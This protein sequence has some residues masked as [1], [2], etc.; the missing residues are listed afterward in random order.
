[1]AMYS[2]I[3]GQLLPNVD[4]VIAKKICNNMVS[5]IAENSNQIHSYK[6]QQTLIDNEIIWPYSCGTDS[7]D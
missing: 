6:G 1:M 2:Q 3:I 4:D 7:C 5:N